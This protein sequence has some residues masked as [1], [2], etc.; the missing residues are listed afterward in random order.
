MV[1]QADVIFA[2]DYENEA[3][4]RARY[5]QSAHKVFM[6]SAYAGE[7]YHRVEI[8]DPY[9]GDEA[10]VRRCYRILEGC[11]HNLAKSLFPDWRGDGAKARELSTSI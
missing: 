2:M 3:L 5:P 8:P 11:M 4:V 7:S 10:E 1:E 6:L 9:W